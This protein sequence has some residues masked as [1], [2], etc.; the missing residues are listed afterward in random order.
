[1]TSLSVRY[2]SGHLNNIPVVP[3][4]P[5]IKVLEAAC[6]KKSLDPKLHKLVHNRK[7][8]DLSIPFRFSGLANRATLELVPCDQ[9]S[10]KV[11]IGVRLQDGYRTE[12]NGMSDSTIWSVLESLASEDQRI[13]DMLVTSSDDLVPTVMYLQNYFRGEENLRDTTLN[14]LAIRDSALFQLMKRPAPPP[15][16]KKE[17]K[18][19]SVS[20][21]PDAP[22]PTESKA[23]TEQSIHSRRKSSR[24][25]SSEASVETSVEE[26]RLPQPSLGAFQQEQNLSQGESAL[27][28]EPF[29][30]FGNTPKRSIKKHKYIFILAFQSMTIGEMLGISLEP[31]SRTSSSEAAAPSQ[32]R[33]FKF[34]C[35]TE[36]QNLMDP[37][38]ESQENETARARPCDREEKIFEKE[39]GTTAVTTSQDDTDELPDQY[40]ELSRAELQRILAD[41]RKVAGRDILLGEQTA[42]KRA[43]QSKVLRFFPRCVIRFIWSDNIVLQACFR[44]LES[45]SALYDFVRERLT[46]QHLSFYLCESLSNFIHG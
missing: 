38:D 10:S 9:T 2:P 18:T 26:A 46:D 7:A 35:E 20:S 21:T 14:S 45:V 31:D 36:G 30:I 42:Q 23:E 41:L 32:S 29:S 43:A 33:E 4:E 37:E 17:L 19:H 15:T 24:E 44:P 3:T 8:V 39:I 12:W 16:T 1:M 5:L 40:F 11:H 25:P 13:A 22:K 6:A 34:P 27:N 28:F